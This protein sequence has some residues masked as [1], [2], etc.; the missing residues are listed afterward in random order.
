MNEQ[1]YRLLAEQSKTK[2]NLKLQDVSQQ[3]W[4]KMVTWWTGMVRINRHWWIRTN[5]FNDV[6]M[7]WNDAANAIDTC[8]VYTMT[9]HIQDY[10]P[11]RVLIDVA[12]AYEARH[13]VQ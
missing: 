10:S 5:T 7:C 4:L 13:A 1:Y 8:S 2:N 6:I 3:R 9:H 12:Y 11:W